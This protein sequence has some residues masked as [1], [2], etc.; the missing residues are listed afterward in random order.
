MNN[1]EKTLSYLR[2]FISR[3]I[4]IMN[5]LESANSKRNDIQPMVEPEIGRFLELIVTLTGAKRVLELGTSNGYSAMWIIAALKRTGG[6]LVTIDSKERLH[7]EAVKNFES[8]GV[9]DYVTPVLGDAE[10][11][12][13]K[14]SP[15]FDVIFQ[16][17]GKYLYPLLFEKVVSLSNPGGVIIADDTLFKVNDDVRPNLGL[18]TD[19]Y[20]NT[21]FN[22]NEL[23][24]A[25]LPVGC[26]LTVSIKL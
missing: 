21:V 24:T 23:L 2:K 12:I 11:E 17:C 10:E 22:N 1:N 8:A 26:G 5:S 9:I 13:E 20:N 15:G 6:H 4:D 16:D 3:P 19:S 7:K 25:I 18:Y 14:L